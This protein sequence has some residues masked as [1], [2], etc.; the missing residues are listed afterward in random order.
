MFSCCDGNMYKFV[1]GTRV[2]EGDSG[3]G[4]KHPIFAIVRQ[5][6]HVVMASKRKYNTNPFE[7]MPRMVYAP[8]DVMRRMQEEKYN[9]TSE[10]NV[11]QRVYGV[12]QPK[13]D[14]EK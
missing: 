5:I 12:P 7:N 3:I 4:D 6:M 8:P 1:F 14:E 11:P 10:R 2:I 9:I 13:L